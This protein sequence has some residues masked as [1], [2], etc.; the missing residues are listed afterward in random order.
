M[1]SVFDTI[2]FVLLVI[3]ILGGIGYLFVL[4]CKVLRKFLRSTSVRKEKEL[5][6]KNLGESIKNHRT[7]CNMTQEFVAEALGISRQAVSKWESG[8]SD[9]STSNLIELAKLFKV[10]PEELL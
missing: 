8:I 3:F 1:P 2:V 5:V 4:I 7:R 9:P 10:S 6:K